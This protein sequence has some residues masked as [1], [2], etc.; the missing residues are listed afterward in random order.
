[1]PYIYVTLAVTF[2]RSLDLRSSP[3]IFEQKRDCSQS[4][5][6]LTAGR[7]QEGSTACECGCHIAQNV[8]SSYLGLGRTIPTF[9]QLPEDEWISNQ[10]RALVYSYFKKGCSCG[11]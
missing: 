11:P 8:C 4:F 5:Q 3:R 10:P 9:M 1:M 7:L 6:K 2:A